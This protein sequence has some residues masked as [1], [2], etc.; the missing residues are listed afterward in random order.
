MN[1]ALLSRTVASIAKDKASTGVTDVEDLR[2]TCYMNV[3]LQAVASIHY[4]VHHIT[5]GL[6]R[7]D[8]SSRSASSG[9]IAEETVRIVLS[10]W[11]QIGQFVS[12]HMFRS[13]VYLHRSVFGVDCMHDAHE[14][15]L[16]LLQ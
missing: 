13:V 9:D 15:L 6:Y 12:V 10:I 2:N 8:L 4:S 5:I 7:E 1:I 16:F 11:S 14:A 3:V